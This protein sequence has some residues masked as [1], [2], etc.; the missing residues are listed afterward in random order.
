MVIK[1]FAFLWLGLELEIFEGTYFKGSAK[2]NGKP[3][4]AKECFEILRHHGKV[5]GHGGS[6]LDGLPLTWAWYMVFCNFRKW[7]ADFQNPLTSTPTCYSFADQVTAKKLIFN[8]KF[9][10]NGKCW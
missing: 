10:A 5:K 7:G 6:C 4:Y 1:D 2:G 8:T 3:Q 9:T